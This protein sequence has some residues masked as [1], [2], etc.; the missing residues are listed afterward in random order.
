MSPG[1]QG[2]CPQ[3]LHLIS[4]LLKLHYVCYAIHILCKLILK[5]KRCYG[6]II[7]KML[8]LKWV[9]TFTVIKNG[10]NF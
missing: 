8:N 2:G 7:N 10:A 4:N 6:V 5:G 1:G 3:E 9:L